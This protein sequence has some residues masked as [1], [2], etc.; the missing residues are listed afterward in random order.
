MLLYLPIWGLLGPKDEDTNYFETPYLFT[1]WQGEALQKTWI[2]KNS[3]CVIQ[4]KESYFT[5]KQTD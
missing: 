2:S 5:V 3:L 4:D 1:S